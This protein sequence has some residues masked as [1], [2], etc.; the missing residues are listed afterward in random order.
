MKKIIV[1]CLLFP[2]SVLA[3]NFDFT[4]GLKLSE[5]SPQAPL[6]ERVYFGGNLGL[7]FG[8]ITRVSFSPQIGFKVSPKASIGA[9]LN[10]EYMRDERFSKSYESHNFGGGLFARYRIIPQIYFH[11][12][13]SYIGYKLTREDIEGERQFVPYLFLGAG[14]SQLVGKNLWVYAEVLFDVLR[15][16]KS[17]YKEWDPFINVGATVGF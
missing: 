13:F 2:L 12:E 9:K 7:K 1:L 14:Y 4:D 5:L 17:P 10:Y 16:S 15:D 6:S 3:S 11:S 8:D